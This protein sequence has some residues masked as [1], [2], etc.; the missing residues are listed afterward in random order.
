M[1]AKHVLVEC[2]VYSLDKVEPEATSLVDR[3]ERLKKRARV[4]DGVELVLA[5][6]TGS[7]G[8]H[9]GGRHVR[10][11]NAAVPSLVR[12]LNADGIPFVFVMNGGLL[13][14]ESVLP[15]PGEE[16]ILEAMAQ[17]GGTAE[18]RN[19]VAISRQALLPY[20]R[21]SYP[22]VEVMASCIQ[23]TSPRECAP[24]AD[25]LRAYDHVVVLNQHTTGA[26]LGTLAGC[27]LG[28]LV[29]FLKLQ[30]GSPDTR[31]CYAD[32]LAHE[33]NPPETIVRELTTR[34]MNALIGSQLRE[35]H[36]GCN[37]D[38]AALIRRPSDLEA[39]VSMGIRQFKVT[40]AQYLFPEEL[41]RLLRLVRER[42]PS[43]A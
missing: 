2:G 42:Q 43:G 25:K 5:P 32:Y 34:P 39:V 28:R 38:L 21:R 12:H 24:Y 40:R 23:Q 36:S 13:F 14:D 41:A 29:V 35:E 18:L 15:D 27:D 11:D 1:A 22:G 30:C 7:S 3:I 10:E 17:A 8:A 19:R 9:R 6:Y 33:D 4:E 16:R 26:F 20:L 31:C 37:W